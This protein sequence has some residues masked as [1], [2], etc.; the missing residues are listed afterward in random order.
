MLKTCTWAEKIE[1]FTFFKVFSQ[2][3]NPHEHFTR[4]PY[5][6]KKKLNQAAH[7]K[8]R[9]QWDETHKFL[10]ADA[11][12]IYQLLQFVDDDWITVCSP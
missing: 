12:S 5:M 11:E 1:I 2:K 4:Y 3:L 7:Q 8:P 6:K 10:F 9:K